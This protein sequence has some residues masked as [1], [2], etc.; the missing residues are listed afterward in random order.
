M[1]VIFRSVS[2]VKSLQIFDV[3]PYFEPVD[4]NRGELPLSST[5]RNQAV[6]QGLRPDRGE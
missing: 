2:R 3:I 6:K 1:K 5:Q 4:L